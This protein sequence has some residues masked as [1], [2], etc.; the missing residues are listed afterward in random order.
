MEENKPFDEEFKVK[1]LDAMGNMANNVKGLREDAAIRISRL[2]ARV[3][4]LIA[5]TEQLQEELDK[6]KAQVEELEVKDFYNQ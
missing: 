6:V 2:E 3:K 4:E 1:I 5:R